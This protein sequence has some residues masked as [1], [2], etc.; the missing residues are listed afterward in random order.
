MRIAT[1]ILAVWGCVATILLLYLVVEHLDSEG[2]VEFNR[3]SEVDYYFPADLQTMNLPH[4]ELTNAVPLS[5][6]AAVRAAME[7]GKERHPGTLVWDVDRISLEQHGK[8]VWLYNIDLVDRESG[9]YSAV[10]VKVLMNGR[11]WKP[12]AR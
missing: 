4:W 11:I 8:G 9:G 10:S 5:P 2:I 3:R 7:Y 6:D 12:V 1:K